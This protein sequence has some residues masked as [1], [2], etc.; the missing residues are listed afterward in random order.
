MSLNVIMKLS[1]TNFQNGM[2][3]NILKFIKIKNNNEQR[4]RK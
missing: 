2:P 4:T 3:R 1:M